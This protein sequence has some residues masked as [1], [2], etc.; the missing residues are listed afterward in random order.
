[1]AEAEEVGKERV[2]E[3]KKRDVFR[4]L[5]LLII[6]VVTGNVAYWMTVVVSFL[7]TIKWHDTWE[8]LQAGHTAKA[9]FYY[10]EAPKTSPDNSVAPPL[11]PLLSIPFVR[12]Q[13][14]G[15]SRAPSP[16]A[17]WRTGRPSPPA[18]ASRRSRRT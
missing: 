16:P 8:Y 9:Y 7:I 18:P 3:N 17:C 4:W 14:A 6:G 1:M 15:S 12:S 5:N 2:R 11:T 13:S 10:R